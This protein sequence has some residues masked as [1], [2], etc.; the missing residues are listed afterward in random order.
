MKAAKL[1]E[2]LQILMKYGEVDVEAQHDIIYCG[3]EDPPTMTDEDR[4][5]LEE[6]G[7]HV[8]SETDSWAH[9]T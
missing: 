5:R 8:D 7:F 3:P 6:L 2:G 4:T 1:V 9:F